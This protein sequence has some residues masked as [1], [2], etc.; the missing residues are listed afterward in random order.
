M[1]KDRIRNISTLPKLCRTCSI[2]YGDIM[3]KMLCFIKWTVADDLPLPTDPTEL[4][5]LTVE[6]F[7][8]LSIPVTDFQ[9]TDV[10]QI[11]R[12]CST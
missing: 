7:A 11:H 3:A 2:H 10:F 6:Q 12:A 8:R 4:G 1:L 9:E 5:L